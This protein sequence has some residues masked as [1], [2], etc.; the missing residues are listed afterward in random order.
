MRRKRTIKLIIVETLRGNCVGLSKFLV[1]T[2]EKVWRISLSLVLSGSC[3]TIWN[4][5]DL[6]ACVC[7]V[8][9]FNLRINI[10]CLTKPSKEIFV[11]PEPPKKEITTLLLHLC[12]LVPWTVFLMLQLWSFEG[13]YLRRNGYNNSDVD[14]GSFSPP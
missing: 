4:Q 7:V 3:E 12:S 5:V 11:F 9:A 8:L 2:E 13:T 6:K 10:S 1:L 14:M